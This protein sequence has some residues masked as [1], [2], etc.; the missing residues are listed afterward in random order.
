MGAGSKIVVTGGAGFIGSNILT[1]L[2]ELGEDRILVVDNLRNADKYRNLVGRTFLDY[3]SK[4]RFLETVEKGDLADIEV[5]FHQGACTD[6]LEYDGEYMMRNNF[7]Y[8]KVL[9]NFC[10]GHNVPFIYASSA[11]VYGHVPAGGGTAPEAPLNIYGYSK[12]LFDQYVRRV[13]PSAPGTLVGLRY[14]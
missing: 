4:E 12:L 9:L 2:N 6:T 10:L 14:F 11:A 8:S 1:R 5:I 13:M 3:L 7:E